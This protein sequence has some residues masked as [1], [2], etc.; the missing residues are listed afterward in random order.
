MRHIFLKTIA[1]LAIVCCFMQVKAQ[2]SAVI[3]PSNTSTG[4]LEKNLLFHAV[5]R[6]QVTSQGPGITLT[7]LFDGNFATTSTTS[8]VTPATPLIIEIDNLP[9]AHTQT[10]AWIGWSTRYYNPIDFKIEGYNAYNS[11]Q[12]VTIDDVTGN[13]QRSYMKKMPSGAFTKLRFT[14]YSTSGTNNILKLSELFYI[15]PEGT[16][17]YDGLAVQYDNDGNVGIG[18]SDPQAKLAVNGNIRAKE[19]KVETTNWPDFVF[20]EDYSLQSLA[21][22]ETYI[23]ANKHLPGVPDKNQAE[24]EGVGLGEMNRKLLEKVE[25]LTLY[26]LQERKERG[27]LA[28]EVTALRQEVDTLKNN[29]K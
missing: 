28:N 9:K 24:K 20:R 27:M 18:T 7:K 15:H 17:F 4:S 16:T 21:E 29:Q 14:F 3:I 2:T 26:L 19:V 5:N 10:G 6:Y 25:E 23:K 8:A 13:S 22:I 12:W 1:L 11:D